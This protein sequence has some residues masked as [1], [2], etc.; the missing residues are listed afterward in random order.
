[1][2][3]DSAPCI[4][5]FFP[6]PTNLS[7][8]VCN[9]WESEKFLDFMNQVPTDVCHCLPDCSATIYEP[10]IISTPLRKCDSSSLGVSKLCNLNNKALPQPTRF[11]SQFLDEFDYIK[12]FPVSAAALRGLQS[13]KRKYGSSLPRGEIFVSNPQTYDAYEKDIALVEIFFRK[14]SIIQMGRKARMNWIDYF[15]TVGGL[16]GLVLGMGIISVI[17]LLWVCL[18][19]AA[20]KMNF[21]N[22]VP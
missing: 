6:T 9:P 8:H 1:M 20:Y 15:S 10:L 17:E 22:L 14:S 21:Q 7:N 5:W 19:L 16:L 12:N 11:G 4:P 13:G 3:K 18:R 2:V